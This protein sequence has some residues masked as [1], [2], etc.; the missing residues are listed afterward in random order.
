MPLICCCC[1]Q[2]LTVTVTVA[3]ADAFEATA[4]ATVTRTAVLLQ[5]LNLLPLLFVLLPLNH[6]CYIS[7]LRYYFYHYY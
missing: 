4:V 2:R 7:F 3:V 1:C 6:Y 5:F